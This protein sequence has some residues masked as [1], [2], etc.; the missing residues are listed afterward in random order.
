MT[1]YKESEVEW[2]KAP[3]DTPVLVSNNGEKWYRRYFAGVNDE[4]KPLVFPDEV[5]NKIPTES[6]RCGGTV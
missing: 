4:G 6:Q 1:K 5:Q 2:N 3:I